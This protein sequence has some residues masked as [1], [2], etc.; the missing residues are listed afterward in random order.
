MPFKYGHS[1]HDVAQAELDS[2]GEFILTEPRRAPTSEALR[3][4]AL[5]VSGARVWDG[6]PPVLSK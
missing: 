4:E 2:L 5:M 1:R 3:L 6:T